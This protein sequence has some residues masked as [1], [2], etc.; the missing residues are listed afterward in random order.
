MLSLLIGI[1]FWTS[2]VLAFIAKQSVGQV[3][4]F[5]AMETFY[6]VLQFGLFGVLIGVIHSSDS[7]GRV[8]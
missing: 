2:H 1:F 7:A 6:L 3:E 5:I 8:G 4:L